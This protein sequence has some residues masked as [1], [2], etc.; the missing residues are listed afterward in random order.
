MT[1]DLPELG[2]STCREY[3]A[4]LGVTRVSLDLAGLTALQSAHLRTQPFHN[5]FLLA[6]DGVDPGLPPV[7]AAV[8]GM[9]RGL[10]GTCHL[11]SPPFVALLRA[12][13]FDATLAAGSVG[14][15]GDHLVGVVR[16]GEGVFLC[17]VGN[18]HPYVRPFRLSR[19]EECQEAFGWSF[20][21]G[22]DRGRD[23]ASYCL[24][25]RLPDGK[26]RTV[27]TLD[28]RPVDYSS[29]ANIIR[30]HHT[31]VGYGPF[32]TGLRAVRMTSEVLLTLRDHQLERF[33]RTGRVG[34]MRLVEGE[35]AFG[36]VLDEC[37]GLGE[38]PW[39]RALEVLR[40]RNP[41]MWARSVEIEDEPLRVLV[42]LGLTDRPGGLDRISAGL[43]RA[44]SHAGWASERVGVLVVNNGT[45]E[46]ALAREVE[47]V[48]TRGVGAVVAPAPVIERWHRRLHESGL[49][50]DP[51][52]SSIVSIGTCRAL[53]VAAVWEHFTSSEGLGPVPRGRSVAVWM[54]DDDLEFAHLEA[55]EGGLSLVTADDLLLRAAALRRA[56]PEASVLVGGT[57]GCPPVPGFA[58]VA[59]QAVDLVRHVA[60]AARSSP[61]GIYRPVRRD[62][63]VPDYYY[64]H[65]DEGAAHQGH[66]FDWEGTD[67]GEMDVRGALLAHLEAIQ[68]IAWGM[69][70]T[71][72]LVH[73]PGR[74]PVST[75]ARGGNALFFDP[76]ALFVAPLLAMRGADG[77]VTRRADTVWAE[78]MAGEPCASVK[79][80][81]LPLHHVRRAGDHSAPSLVG[82]STSSL[83]RFV[84]AQSRGTVLARLMRGRR[85]GESTSAAALLEE[86]ASRL[87]RSVEI[88]R[89]ESDALRRQES[90]RSTWWSRD[91]EVR[92]AMLRALAVLDRAAVLLAEVPALDETGEVAADLEACADAAPHA[93]TRWRALWT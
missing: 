81:P 27:Y 2:S 82:P 9:L 60:E 68:G 93:V 41:Q 15:T 35:R 83:C 18:G 69:P 29:F 91:E 20:I 79:A 73:D 10:G 47:A 62:R 61:T 51:L 36:R 17:D 72:L 39:R 70:A 63:T 78:L 89:R 32:M 85:L 13:G 55:R 11:L 1:T 23:D 7:E 66:G 58:F 3:L 44:C 22:P 74:E 90:A 31:R 16:L 87:R 56:H 76:D 34:G 33:H 49:V 77:I 45:N 86:R 71:R 84:A 57:T 4:R 88:V 25:R 67:A 21:F 46:G 37:F 75:I 40:G 14:A 8:E 6:G 80:A 30:A 43:A 19:E 59:S 92:A 26:W 42:T 64:D 38:L 50:A 54:L 28:P 48:R 24:R 5:I 65:S 53:Q 12:L 52:G